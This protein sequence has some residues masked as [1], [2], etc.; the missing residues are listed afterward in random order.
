[1]TARM[2]FPVLLAAAG[3]CTHLASYG[4]QRLLRLD[5]LQFIGV[6]NAYHI[7]PDAALRTLW[8]SQYR[9]APTGERP[10]ETLMYSHP[11]L[12]TQSELGIRFF[13]LDLHLDPRGDRYSGEG[14]LAPVLAADLD[15]DAAFDSE[16]RLSRPGTKVFHTLQDMRSTCLLLADCL[17]ELLAWM[18]QNPGK[19]PVIVQFEPKDLLPNDHDGSR[20]WTMLEAEILEIVPE[21]RIYRPGD[22]AADPANLRQAAISK[23]WR[24]S[25]AVAD[26]FVFVLNGSTVDT[27]SYTEALIDRRARLMFPAMSNAEHPVAAV[28]SRND[29]FA[30]DIAAISS[31]GQ[32]VITYADWRT[33]P[34]RNNDTRGRDSAFQSG[35]QFIVTDY[36]APDRRLSNYSVRFPEGFMR[37][38]P[39]ARTVEPAS[40]AK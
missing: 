4:D 25:A 20:S 35:A 32:L 8:Q 12:R 24:A 33:T 39:T 31:R 23:H 1:M 30:P 6:H 3:A 38:R 5:E 37:A 9:N 21:A 22:L 14:F 7:E 26:H 28:V 15:P 10:F 36:P 40:Q 27:N 11:P 18:E 2:L 34:A 19:G 13:E 16:R 29:P 17:S